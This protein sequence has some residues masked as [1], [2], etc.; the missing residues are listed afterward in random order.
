MPNYSRI[1][2]SGTRVDSSNADP[3]IAWSAGN[4]LVALNYQTLDMPML[5]NHGMFMQNGSCGYVLKP[6]YMLD[7]SKLPTPP[8]TLRVHV[9]SGH[10]LPRP[11]GLSM[12]E[13]STSPYI[14]IFK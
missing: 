8:I 3:I 5:V 2:P 7:S 14:S 9:I 12:A 13:V 1:Y 10:Q 11:V 6:E 4:Q